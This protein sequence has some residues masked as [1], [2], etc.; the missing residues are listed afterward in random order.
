MNKEDLKGK[1]SKASY[2]VTQEHGT[3]APFSPVNFWIQKRK[4]FLLVFV[5]AMSFFP[6]IQNMIPELDG[7]A[8]GM[9]LIKILLVKKLTKV[10]G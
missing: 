2:I 8:F 6:Q 1:I 5:V 3:E 7:Q 9:F 4:V 10:M